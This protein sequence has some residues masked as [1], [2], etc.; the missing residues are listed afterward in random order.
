MKIDMSDIARGRR[1]V[2][3]AA[4]ELA[5]TRQSARPS[6]IRLLRRVFRTLFLRRG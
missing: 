2:A 1:I 4:H 3:V 6:R 5:L